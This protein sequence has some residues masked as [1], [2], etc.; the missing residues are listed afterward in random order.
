M[1]LYTGKFLYL[2]LLITVVSTVVFVGCVL[3]LLM[4]T[5]KSEKVLFGE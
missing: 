3:W 2:N 1:D 5:F 4:K